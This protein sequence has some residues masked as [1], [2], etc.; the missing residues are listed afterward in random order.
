M[1]LTL[2]EVHHT[3]RPSEKIFR[4]AR[5]KLSV[6]VLSIVYNSADIPDPVLE[7]L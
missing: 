3:P 7:D 1:Y 2:Q 4:K 5:D 6:E